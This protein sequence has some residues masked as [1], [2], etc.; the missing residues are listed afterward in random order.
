MSSVLPLINAPPTGA[1]MAVPLAGAAALAVWRA[2]ELGHADFKTC[3]T[4]FAALD[5]ELP[6]GGWPRGAVTELLQPQYSVAEWRLLLPA[7]APLATASRPLIVV[8]PPHEPYAAGLRR[9]GLPERHLVLVRAD[10]PA[11]RLWAV[12]QAAKASGLA[13]VIA[14]LPNARASQLRRL[15]VLAAQTEALIFAVRPEAA[16]HESSPAPLRLLVRLEGVDGL[17]VHVLKRR[18]Q[19]HDG[20]L[21][22]RAW[23]PG[24]ERIVVPRPPQAETPWSLPLRR[25]EGADAVLAR[26][27]HAI[28]HAA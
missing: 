16:Q 2:T 26:A 19:P 17:D 25:M 24:L 27:A 14:W 12:E 6:G 20:R 3:G 10:S 1:G 5:A 9:Y 11:R 4:G 15:Q 18:G 13:A 28:D 22:L 8:S 7:I 21:Q 23:P